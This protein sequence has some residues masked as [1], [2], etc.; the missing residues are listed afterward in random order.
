MAG[1]ATSKT[2]TKK[3]CVW[4]VVKRYGTT[5]TIEGAWVCLGSPNHPCVSTA[6]DGSY[7]LCDEPNATYTLAATKEGYQHYSGS[8][9]IP[10]AKN[11]SMRPLTTKTRMCVWGVIKDCRTGNPLE[12]V[13][14]CLGSPAHPCVTTAADGGFVICDQPGVYTLTATK[15]GYQPYSGL[16]TIPRSTP[17]KF[18]MQPL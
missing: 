15:E 3:G 17:R 18:C 9:T 16:V 1:K 6:S 8:V 12:G 5:Q 11:F 13:T 7:T 14:I 4:G 10:H 2:D